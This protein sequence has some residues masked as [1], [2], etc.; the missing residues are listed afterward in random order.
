MKSLAKYMSEKQWPHTMLAEGKDS[1]QWL[2]SGRV[3]PGFWEVHILK[4][5][6]LEEFLSKEGAEKT[7]SLEPLNNI[8][9]LN[10]DTQ[11]RWSVTK[12]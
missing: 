2:V 6:E 8:T 9:I 10:P 1:K 4:E 7:L 5:N 3:K 12:L 11:I